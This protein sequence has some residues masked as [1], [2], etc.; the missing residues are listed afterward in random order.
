M[1]ITFPEYQP[2][3][4]SDTSLVRGGMR[5]VEFKVNGTDLSQYCIMSQDTMI[6]NGRF[7]QLKHITQTY[8]LTHS[9]LHRWRPGQERRQKTWPTWDT[10]TLTVAP[11]RWRKSVSLWNCRYVFK[12]DIKP[13]CGILLFGPPGTGKTFIACAVANKTGAF[14]FLINGP[15]NSLAIIFIDEIDSIAPKREKVC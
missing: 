12:V 15:E 1:L 3:S 14:L 7:H 8:L 5:T 6:H 10:T 2:V 4:K 11:N 13:P 9:H